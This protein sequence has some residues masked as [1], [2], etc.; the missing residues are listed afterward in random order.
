MK[1]I[2]NGPMLQIKYVTWQVQR[3][4]L[5]AQSVEAFSM[6]E[7]QDMMQNS[8]IPSCQINRLWTQGGYG[9]TLG[10][11]HLPALESLGPGPA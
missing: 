6:L 9:L 11:A 10:S 7:A 1:G 2:R 3:R 5:Y 8:G 4:N